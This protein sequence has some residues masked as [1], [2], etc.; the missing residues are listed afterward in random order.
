MPNT[1]NGGAPQLAGHIYIRATK[2]A[3]GLAWREGCTLYWG[4]TFPAWPVVGLVVLAVPDSH[5]VRTHARRRAASEGRPSSPS[6]SPPP[7]HTMIPNPPS[8]A[9]EHHMS[10]EP[11]ASLLETYSRDE[12]RVTTARSPTGGL[13]CSVAAHAARVRL[14]DPG[15]F[16]SPSTCTRPNI[17]R[18]A[19]FDSHQQRPRNPAVL[20]ALRRCG[21]T[22]PGAPSAR[23]CRC[24]YCYPP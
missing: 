21:I 6:W 1:A 23:R 15:Q 5:L 13:T 17:P 7:P 14:R 22:L 8:S 3:T 20:G 24:S 11:V 4:K 16:H 2:Q 10:P 18:P 9:G 12:S 19:R